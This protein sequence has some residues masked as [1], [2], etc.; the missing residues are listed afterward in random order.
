MRLI[1]LIASLM[2]L[3]S[4]SA[5]LRWETLN[6]PGS[7]GCLTSLRPDPR[8]P[9]HLLLGGDMLGIGVSPDGG[10]TWTG[11]YGLLSWEIGDLT[12]HPTRP[13]EVWAGTMSGP[14]VSTDGGM[15]WESRRQGLPDVSPG[16][17]SAPIQRILIDPA[18]PDRLLAFAGTYRG[19]SSP[20]TPK[21]GYVWESLDA[22]KSWKELSAVRAFRNITW[23]DA[24]RSWRRLYAVVEGRGVYTS[25]DRGKSWKEANSGLPA[26]G[27]I[28]MV[29]VHPDR[30]DT[31]WVAHG[32]HLKRA[33]SHEWLPGGIYVTT[34]GGRSWKPSGT[35]LP[36]RPGDNPH[37]T[38]RF[39]A[40]AV[41]PVNPNHLA[42]S[43]TSWNNDAVYFSSDG[44]KSWK[45]VLDK[46]AM[47]AIPVAYPAGM[48]ASV[49]TFCP[50]SPLTFY[51]ANT[52]SVLRTTDGGTT[53]TDLTASRPAPDATTWRGH[54]YSGLCSMRIVFNPFRPGSVILT[55][56]DAGKHLR[57]DDGLASWFFYDSGFSQPWGGGNDA[58]FAGPDGTTTWLAI[59][60]HGT[61]GA[62][63]RSDDGGRTWREFHGESRGLP[64]QAQ[65]NA[66]H[67]DPANPDLVWAVM[68]DGLYHSTNGGESWTRHP[69]LRGATTIGKTPGQ[70][71]PFYVGTADGVHR[72]TDGT[73]F[74]LI[75]DSPAAP[76]RITV[77]AQTPDRLY[78]VRHRHEGGGVFRYDG[79]SWTRVFSD[80]HAHEIAVSP[81]NPEHLAVATTDDPFHDHSRASGV[82][83]SLDG[84]KNWQQANQGLSC[85]RGHAIAFDPHDPTRLIFGSFGRGFFQ[86]RWPASPAP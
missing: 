62:I 73:T 57:S 5:A 65:A 36:S 86:A 16:S 24:D 29:A 35:G 20:G 77:P 37:Y 67:C 74:K 23:A 13:G 50:R 18:N 60:Q 81:A 78:A 84:G 69:N 3:L 40:I 70:A 31:A 53:W 79:G 66:V 52:E 45:K 42:T 7:G 38:T 55:A 46:P 17:Y 72:T 11:G 68:G 1:C 32:N 41:S 49:I 28:R 10:Q 21:F 25:D 75:K 8:N 9:G 19:W 47:A 4:A 61:M 44:G 64:G 71:F 26:P 58:A 34:D 30:P 76:S 48:G 51:V 2:P 39:Q 63:A 14:Y 43:D 54:G 22:G 6:E 85:L 80:I 56:M 12:F 82:W 59:G 27:S 33:G 15:N 83:I